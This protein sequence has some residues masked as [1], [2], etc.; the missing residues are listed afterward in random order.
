M[1]TIFMMRFHNSFLSSTTKIAY[2]TTGSFDK[3][4]K[5]EGDSVN[6]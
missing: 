3:N 5:A 1:G 6:W 4:R 2:S